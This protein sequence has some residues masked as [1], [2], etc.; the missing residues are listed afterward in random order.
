MGS[1]VIFNGTKVKSLKKILSLNAGAEVVSSTTDPTSSAVDAP[2]GSLLLN[3][4]TGLVYRKLDAGSS[5]NWVLLLQPDASNE[6]SN[7]TLTASVAS[8]ALTVAV[9]NKAGSDP[10]AASPVRV[11]FR[12][13]TAATGTYLQRSLAAALSQVISSG[14]TLGHASG[15]THYIYVYLIDSDGAGAL[16]LG[17]SSSLLD[18]GSLQTT[19]AEG[20]AGAAD[21]AASLYSDAVYSNKPVRLIGR[22]KSNQTTAGTWASAPTEISLVPFEAQVVNARY[23]TTAGQSITNGT[24]P[25]VDFGTKDYDS[26]NSVTTGASWK[27]TAPVAGRYSVQCTITWSS[28]SSF[29]STNAIRMDI[30]KNGSFHSRLHILGIEATVSVSRSTTGGDTVNLAVGDFIDIRVNHDESTARSISTAAGG[31]HVSIDRVG[32]F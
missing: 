16:K 30:Y 26:H 13:N 5:T 23:T 25:Q 6:I 27:F 32:N 2:I 1:A 17:L 20:G 19:V 4:T 22:L 18:D 28:A 31:T 14:S 7:L 8:N 3:E 24:T 11:G 9:K 10:S 29:T 21:S 12:N 15:V